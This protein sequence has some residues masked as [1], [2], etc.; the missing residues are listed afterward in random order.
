VAALAGFVVLGQQFG[1]IDA[2]AVALVV[3]AGMGAIRT[4][5]PIKAP[6]PADT[7]SPQTSSK[8]PRGDLAQQRTIF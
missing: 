4:A 8:E 1:L 3:V 6:G 5:S 7:C 2:L